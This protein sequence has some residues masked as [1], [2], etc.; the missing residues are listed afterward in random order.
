MTLTPE[1]HQNTQRLQGG[2][3]SQKF[4]SAAAGTLHQG[5]IP[6]LRQALSLAVVIQGSPN[7]ATAQIMILYTNIFTIF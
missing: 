3:N 2:Q 4:V 7:V 5:Q 1:K 6:S